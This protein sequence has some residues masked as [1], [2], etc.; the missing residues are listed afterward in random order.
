MADPRPS[1]NGASEVREEMKQIIGDEHRNTILAMSNLAL[2]L[3]NQ[4]K[5]DEAARM[6]R[7]VLER[8]KRILGEDEHPN[9]VLAMS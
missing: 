5:T 7:E 6:F 3:P 2:T 4:C 9:T 1:K 8:M